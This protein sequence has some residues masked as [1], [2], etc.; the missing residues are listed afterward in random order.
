[1]DSGRR[2][3]N[4]PAGTSLIEEAAR[5]FCDIETEGGDLTVRSLLDRLMAEDG[6]DRPRIGTR[7]M[8]SQRK[9]ARFSFD[10]EEVADARPGLWWPAPGI[11]EPS[12]L[13]VG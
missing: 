1:M 13:R 5:K 11:G 7:H 3:S 2:A 4:A 12:P 10:R 9:G 6:G 8:P